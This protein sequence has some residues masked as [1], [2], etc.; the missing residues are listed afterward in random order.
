MNIEEYC[1]DMIE[2]FGDLPDP[3]H[4]PAKFA[5]YV[6]LYYHILKLNEDN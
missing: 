5:Y 2:L 1:N 3:E 6:R 4:Q